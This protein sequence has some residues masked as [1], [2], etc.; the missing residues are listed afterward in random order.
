[1]ETFFE[2]LSQ[3][4]LFYDIEQSNLDSMLKCLDG[5]VVQILKGSPVFLEGTPAQY[6]LLWTTTM[7]IEAF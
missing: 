3:C 4:P 5:K 7:G 6:R 1:M 2:I